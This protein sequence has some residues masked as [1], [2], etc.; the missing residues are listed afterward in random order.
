M[1]FKIMLDELIDDLIFWLFLRLFGAV[2]VESPPFNITVGLL[3]E[4]KLLLRSC[5]SVEV[6]R[7]LVL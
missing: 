5:D 7:E 4:L 3:N 2:F 1:S 6:L